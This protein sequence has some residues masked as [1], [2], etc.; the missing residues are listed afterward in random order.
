MLGSMSFRHRLHR[1]HRL[2]HAVQPHSHHHHHDH[3]TRAELENPAEGWRALWIS[4]AGLAA[5]AGVQVV[6][7]A[8]SGSVA[9]FGDALHNAAD[10]LTAVPL[11]TAFLLARRHP[12]RRYTYGYGR[13]EDLAG[14]AIV[15]AI[16]VSCAVAM[17]VSV[18]RLA[19]PR[20]VSHL[21]AVAV[22]ALVGFAGNELVARYRMTVGRRIGSAALVADGLHARAD[23]FTSLAVLAGAGGMA[24]GWTWADPV[25][26][27][28]IT[29]AIL[30]AGW[31]AAR[32]V[33]RRLMD[34]VDPALTDQACSTLRATSGVL[35]AG[36]VRLR[37]V[38]RRLR[39]E[40]SI[41][42]DPDC[43]LVQAHAVA[44]RA[45]HALIHAVPGLA[46]ALVHA[47]PAGDAAHHALLADH[48]LA[49]HT[50]AG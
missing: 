7:V 37:W 47:D 44:V 9:L 40:C 19:Q 21:A 16:G 39:A 33:G 4:L 2:R 27:L 14:V 5:T 34:G 41:L 45:E 18:Q 25:A 15:A 29:A 12:T 1:L 49:D 36:P 3:G 8:L 46:A 32:D 22:A 23:G 48:A 35:G 42:V 31:Q 28:A 6:V 30:T 50:L 13:A 38:G 11:G 26:G 20:P 17:V 10:A 43:S 24:L